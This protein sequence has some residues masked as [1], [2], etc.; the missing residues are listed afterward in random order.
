MHTENAQLATAPIDA[1]NVQVAVASLLGVPIWSSLVW[2]AL[3]QVSVKLVTCHH[4][5][6]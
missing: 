4:V 3:E 2:H 1:L 5:Q 6:I